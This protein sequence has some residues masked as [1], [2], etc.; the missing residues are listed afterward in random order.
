MPTPEE[1]LGRTAVRIERN[2]ARIAHTLEAMAKESVPNFKTLEESAEIL[3][4]QVQDKLESL[5]PGTR[6]ESRGTQ[7]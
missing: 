2:L 5:K 3:R 1:V 7:P 6:P 4:K